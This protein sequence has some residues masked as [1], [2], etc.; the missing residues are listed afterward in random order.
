MRS[1]G[2]HPSYPYSLMVGIYF[3]IV[4][5]SVGLWSNIRCKLST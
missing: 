1:I 4:V 5:K 2:N 3:N